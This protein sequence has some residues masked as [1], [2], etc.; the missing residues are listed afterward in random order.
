[1]SARGLTRGAWAIAAIG[2]ALYFAART[3]GAGWLIVILCG[4][5]GTLAV[6]TV[7]P[8]FALSRLRLSGSAPADGAV[9]VPLE[10]VVTVARSGLG[11]RLRPLDPPGPPTATPGDG[12]L[13][14]ALAPD[15]RG[16]RREILVEVSSAAPFGLV[17]WRRRR[18]IPLARPLDIAPRRGLALQGL[19]GGG[20][21]GGDAAVPAGAGGDRVRAVREYVPGD[22]MRLV[23]WPATARTG[24]VVVKE[25]ELP[26]R[27]LLRVVVDLRG[28]VAAAE[29]AAE[30]AMGLVCDAL[31]AG[32]QVVLATLQADGPVIE[33]VTSAR[34]AG[35]R[36]A[37]AVAGPPPSFPPDVPA[38]RVATTGGSRR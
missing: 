24:Q 32:C 26:E 31:E 10:A 28:D 2:A 20:A 8:P 23:H 33:Q 3:T 25:L 36:L 15:R 21:D 16:V 34:A 37:R 18:R 17:W 38:V 14:V 12:P 5:G 4:L 35:R 6:A 27:P 1:M 11:V 13:T 29:E 9:D 30:R 7:W 22:P 19:L